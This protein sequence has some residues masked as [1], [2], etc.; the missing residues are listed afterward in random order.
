MQQAKTDMTIDISAVVHASSVIEA[1]ATI[2]ANCKIG[3]FCH[4]GSNVILGEGVELYS[5][6]VLAGNTDIGADTR[7]WPFASVGHQ[8]Q[9]LKFDGEDTRLVIGERCMIRESVSINPGTSGGGG[10]TKIG[11]DCLLMLGAHVGHDCLVANRVIM[12]NNVALAGHV[13]IED[14]VI[15]GGLSGIH[16]FCKIGRGAVIGAVVMVT[17]DVIPYGAVVAERPYLAG[18]N[19]VGLKRRGAN[20]YDVNKLRAAFSDV[21]SNTGTLKER[22]AQ[23]RIDYA[24]D[25]LVSEVLDFLEGPSSR[26]FLLPQRDA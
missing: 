20:K 18:L 12:A 6:V 13:V 16:Q 19:L 9:D 3:P 25:V 17:N 8:P 4:I 26:S 2:G 10:L 22:T 14:D 15:I 23:A 24:G 21:F 7:I 5:H 11:D 1:G